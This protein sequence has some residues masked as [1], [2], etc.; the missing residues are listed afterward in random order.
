MEKKKFSSHHMQVTAAIVHTSDSNSETLQEPN[1]NSGSIIAEKIPEENVR[2]VETIENNG[3]AHHQN[4]SDFPA[5][6]RKKL[7]FNPAYFERQLLKV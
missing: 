2:I 5:T 1:C 4:N 6:Q 3:A 7:Y